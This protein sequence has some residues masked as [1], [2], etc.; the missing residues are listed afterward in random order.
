MNGVPIK[1]VFLIVFIAVILSGITVF[2]PTYYLTKRTADP[3][4]TN[5]TSQIPSILKA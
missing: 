1:R 4:L 5:P 3:S 2:L